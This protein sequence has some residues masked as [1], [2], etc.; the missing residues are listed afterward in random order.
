MYVIFSHSTLHF[1]AYD[2]NTIYKTRQKHKTYSVISFYKALVRRAPVISAFG[3][4]VHT[5][6][7]AYIDTLSMTLIQLMFKVAP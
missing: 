5:H 2:E 7:L 4:T 1:A 3:R 6:A